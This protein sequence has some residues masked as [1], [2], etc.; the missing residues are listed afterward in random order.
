MKQFTLQPDQNSGSKGSVDFLNGLN[1]QQKK[2]V[3][4]TQGPLLIIA[5]AGSGKTRVLTYRIA[6]LLQQHKAMPHEILALT[7]TNKAARE[8]QD[9]IRS[10]IGD[11]AGKLWMGTFHSI[12]SKILRFEAEK[13][14]FDS[15]FSIY[16]TSDSESAIKLILG[17]LNYDPREIRPRTIQRKISD[18]KNQLITPNDYKHRFVSSTLDDIT[19]R[20]FEVYDVR[21][22]QANAMDF[23]DLLIKPIELFEQHP[24][25]LEKYQDRFKHILI[26]EY[27][28]TN[29]AQ[30]KMT[31]MLAEKYQNICVVGDDAQSIYSFRGADISNILNFKSDYNEAKQVPLEQNYRSTKYILQC[32]D[33]IIKNNDKQLEKTLWTENADGH[34][35]T[36]LENF[37]ERDE[38]NRVVQH[39]Q[40]LKMRDGYT[41]N[42]FAILY[43]TNYQSRVFEEALRRKGIAYQLVGGLSFYQRKEIKDV[44]AYL[45]LLV[46]PEDEQALLRIIN[47]PS[48][49]IGKK[50]LNDLLK[51]SRNQKRSVWSIIQDVEGT[52]LY[53]PAI[54]RIG[55]FV[56]MIHNLRKELE[57]GASLL[58]TTKKMLDASGYVKSLIEENSAKAL[59]RRDNILE[60][61]NAISYYEQH[62]KKPTLSSFLQEIS[63][64]TDTDKYDEDKPAVTMMTVHGSKGLEFPVVF[65][66]G[67]EEKLFPM[68]GR[69]GEEADFEEERRLFYVAI[70][71]AEETLYFSFAKM[72]YRFGEQTQQMRSRFLDEVDPGVVRTESGATIEQK[73]DR[74]ENDETT[75]DYGTEIEY[76]WKKPKQSKKPSNSGLDFET[77][78]DDDPYQA[79]TTVMHP[80]FGPGKILQRTGSGKDSKV[81][82]FFKQR[83]Q[84]TLMLRAAR[85]KVL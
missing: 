66:V 54:S 69:N 80:T 24:D 51:K 57:Q 62:N 16:D 38:A 59:T 82:V 50:T 21:L 83:G 33:S 30:Y 2:A 6:Y 77:T 43:R 79:G 46:N 72:R 67:L 20:V 63:L 84:K 1:K 65:I 76:D 28:D 53:K 40:N 52:D 5:G 35:I 78:Y 32:A 56:S 31:R 55:N 10:L 36:L 13:I 81:V 85:L 49:G 70:T 75:I 73:R 64:I 15:N 14:G 45:T 42:D 19:A 37:D 60:L 47:E 9:R 12:F 8:M 74:F 29:H 18:A 48:R 61:Q 41:N 26:D 44:L 17:E 22:R 7:F 23:D 39:I 3:T 71:R 34:P 68:G 11:R 25:V 27:Q 4:H 58:D